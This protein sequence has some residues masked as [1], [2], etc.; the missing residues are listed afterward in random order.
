MDWFWMTG[1]VLLVCFFVFI[2]LLCKAV[3]TD[4]KEYPEKYRNP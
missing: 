4:K 2:I 1:K 3:E